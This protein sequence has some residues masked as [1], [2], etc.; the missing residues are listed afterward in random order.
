M[1]FWWLQ[2]QFQKAT[3]LWQALTRWKR[4]PGTH[5]DLDE[6]PTGLEGLLRDFEPSTRIWNTR[7][8]WQTEGRSLAGKANKV[9]IEDRWAEKGLPVQPLHP[10]RQQGRQ[11]SY[12]K[13]AEKTRTETAPTVITRITLRFRGERGLEAKHET[14]SIC[15]DWARAEGSTRTDELPGDG[16]RAIGSVSNQGLMSSASSKNR[17]ENAAYPSTTPP[18]HRHKTSIYRNGLFFTRFG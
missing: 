5:V 7:G 3:R 15:E 10:G 12:Y 16:P 1:R 13:N 8:L 9:V 17:N 14:F 2:Q 11:M 4:G 6:L 18:T